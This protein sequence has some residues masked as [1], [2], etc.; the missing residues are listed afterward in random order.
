MIEAYDGNCKRIALHSRRYS[1]PRYATHKEHMPDHHRFKAMADRFDGERY[2]SWASDIGEHTFFVID[3]LL[4]NAD[5]QEKAYRSCMGILQFSKEHG[6][7]RL[8]AACKKA[9]ELSSPCYRTIY[10][11]LKNRQEQTTQGEL[12][13]PLD[14]H[15]N[16]R[17]AASFA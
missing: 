16:L 12:F 15:E 5:I 8:E 9:R 7:S 14:T 1:G 13:K 10:N 11:I 4:S 6:A 2:R 3:T 17:G